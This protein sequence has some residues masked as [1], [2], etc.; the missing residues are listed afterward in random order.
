M[1]KPLL[2][3]SP[4][5]PPAVEPTV[6]IVDDDAAVR[7]ALQLLARSYGWNAQ[8][9]D[10]GA[11]L[12]QSELHERDACIVLD[13]NMPAPDGAEV[14]RRLR[15]RGCSIPVLLIS[16]DRHGPR[17]ERVLRDGAQAALAKP[18]GDQAFHDAVQACL[19]ASPPS[20]T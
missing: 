6:Y 16:G 18:F 11:S 15:Q 9:F 12:L 7:I 20:D 4:D 3:Y 8:G 14:L 19:A 1:P 5:P 2:W 17:L 10:S 13:L